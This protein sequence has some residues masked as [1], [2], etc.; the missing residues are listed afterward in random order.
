M[1]TLKGENPHS[2]LAV[3]RW[4]KC[5][6]LMTTPQ[7]FHNFRTGILETITAAYNDLTPATFQMLLDRNPPHL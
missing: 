5:K 4:I 7:E 1:L 3:F 6:L 2:V